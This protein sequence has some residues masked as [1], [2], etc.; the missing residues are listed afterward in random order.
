MVCQLSCFKN[1]MCAQI[2]VLIKMEPPRV[3][4]TLKK[5]FSFV[6]FVESYTSFKSGVFPCALNACLVL[7]K[8]VAPLCQ[9]R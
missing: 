7:A 3:R 5:G 9:I 1:T 6:I 2:L 4:G 8:L